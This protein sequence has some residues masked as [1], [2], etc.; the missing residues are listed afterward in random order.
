M[1][2]F[3]TFLSWKYCVCTGI[4]FVCYKWQWV[5]AAAGWCVL[6]G[7]SLSPTEAS[8]DVLSQLQDYANI[9]SS[10]ADTKQLAVVAF[11]YVF[12]CIAPAN[13]WGLRC[14]VWRNVFLW[15]GLGLFVNDYFM[16]AS[17][18]C[19]RE[20]HNIECFHCHRHN[21]VMFRVCSLY[22]H[23]LVVLE[24]EIFVLDKTCVCM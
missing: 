20:A 10:N 6:V 24:F 9:S 17:G 5:Y 13:G 23:N 19:S 1:Q 14:S 16:A 18:I 8:A 22:T 11:L 15:S 2:L 3:V 12:C 21:F 7:D 4:N